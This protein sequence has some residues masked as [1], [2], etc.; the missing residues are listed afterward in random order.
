MATIKDISHR[1]GLSIGTIS[2]YLNGKN[3]LPQNAN[4]IQKAI[5][6]LHYQVNPLA[7]GLK[8]SQTFTIGFLTHHWESTFFLRVVSIIENTLHEYGYSLIVCAYNG[9]EKQERDKF[10]MLSQ[11]VDALVIQP[12]HIDGDFITKNLNRSIPIIS[13]DRPISGYDCDNVL[14]NNLNSCYMAVEA[15]IQ[16]GHRKIALLAGTKDLYTTKNRVTA[17]K[18]VFEDY[19]LVYNETMI[20]YG[21]YQQKTGFDITSKLLEASDPPTAIYASTNEMTLGALSAFDKYGISVPNDIS[22]IGSD[23]ISQ[24][25]VYAKQYSQVYQPVEAFGKAVSELLIKR[26]FSEEPSEPETLRLK[27]EFYDKGSIKPY[28]KYS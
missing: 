15:L 2:K 21:N 28:V 25:G 9:N 17:F 1:T 13:I 24:S 11:R 6:E 14:V 26:L 10:C 18:R 4:L 19:E 3:V 8:T 16:N 23:I 5:D 27:S 12:Y 22:F 7:R 20:C